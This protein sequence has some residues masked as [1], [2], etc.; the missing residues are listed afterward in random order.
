MATGPILPSAQ[1]Q[2][3]A[4]VETPGVVEKTSYT[5]E[6]TSVGYRLL[7]KS[8]WKEGTGLGPDGKGCKVPVEAW[9]NRGRR[10]V[11]CP[12]QRQKAPETSTDVLKTKKK[13]KKKKRKRKKTGPKV[14][15]PAGSE[16]EQEEQLKIAVAR[17][18]ARQAAIQRA[19]RRELN[20][21]NTE[22][23]TNPLTR[24]NRL[25]DLNPLL[26]D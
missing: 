22:G 26:D 11:G 13:K 9:H 2:E 23:G 5:V 20:E 25:S 19:L 17:E 24:M 14:G 12:D 21:E 10:G 3:K 8:G 1:V 7:K 16:T 6:P 18:T 15:S 4:V